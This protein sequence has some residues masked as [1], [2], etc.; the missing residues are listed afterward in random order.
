VRLLA[1]PIALN[2][3]K[4]MDT[5]LPSFEDA[6][7]GFS[8]FLAEHGEP[9]EIHWIYGEATTRWM[10]DWLIFDQGSSANLDSVR[11]AYGHG[12]ESGLGV[13]L[14]QLGSA[15]GVSYC[16]V[17]VPDDMVD[18]EQCM[19]DGSVKYTMPQDS[20]PSTVKVTE[21]TF[22]FAYRRLMNF[23]RRRFRKL[24]SWNMLPHSPTRAS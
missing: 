6:R 20:F 1:E 24:A 15:D 22:V 16:Y 11:I 17:W 18:A 3:M 14:D 9:S 23:V 8:E 2:V 5:E 13:S 10:R 4:P 19:M 21:S 7:H 12:V